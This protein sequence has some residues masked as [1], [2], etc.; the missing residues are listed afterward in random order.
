MKQPLTIARIQTAKVSAGAAEMK[1]WDGTVSGLC[2]RVFAGGGRTWTYRYRADGGG[3]SAKIRTLKLGSYP[4][5]SI[6][7]ARN[8]ARTHAGQVAKGQDP[9][10]ERQETRRSET[11]AVGMLLAVGGPYER[12]LKA[13]HIVKTAQVLSRLR[14]GL[15]RFKHVDIAKLSRRDLVGCI[16]ALGDQ[17]GAQTELRKC[18]RVLLEWAV[19]GG[20]APANVLAGWRAPQQSRTQKLAAVARRRA[21][22]DP[23]IVAV[24][25][26][27]GRCGTYGAL[28]RLALCTAMRRNELATLRW[29]DIHADR[30]VL[31]AA[32]T[33]TATQHQVPLTALMCHVLD[34]RPPGVSPVVF[35][36][37]VTGRVIANWHSARQQ[38][39]READVGEFTLHDLRRTC[40]TLM[41][42]L[43]VA[44]PTAELAIGHAPAALLAAYD[45]DTQWTARVDAFN[46]V[47]VHIAKIIS[48]PD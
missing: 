41:T 17:P 20:L 18:T 12:S 26:A 24:W 9:A 23:D 13:R 45:L 32:T 27:A 30:I 6:D 42:R 47:S 36:S 21:L 8:A 10:Q 48:R 46:R 7:A 39:M 14:R 33:K 5:L 4:A 16:D 40:R 15:D 31:S 22:T 25:R 37:N 34:N 44:E 29:D 3:R 2:L 38:L 28:V 1:L 43:G 19:N 11:A 35:P